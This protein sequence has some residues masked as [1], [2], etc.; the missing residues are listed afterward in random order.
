MSS[1]NKVQRRRGKIDKEKR[2]VEKRREEGWVEKEKKEKKREEE[3]RRR[4]GERAKN[5][6]K[7]KKKKKNQLVKREL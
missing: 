5:K 6:G 1:K 7:N 3:R 4:E 2:G